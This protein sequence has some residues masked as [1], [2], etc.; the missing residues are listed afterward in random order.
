MLDYSLDT[1]QDAQLIKDTIQQVKNIYGK[2]KNILFHSDQG[3]KFTRYIVTD[4]CKQQTL[5]QS[6]PRKGNCW[7][8]AVIESFFNT[9]KRECLHGEKLVSLFQVN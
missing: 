3:L 8:N 2:Q 6:M 9:F 1:C 4:C 7:G 5:Q